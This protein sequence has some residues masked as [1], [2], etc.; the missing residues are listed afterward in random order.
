ME[1]I[2]KPAIPEHRGSVRE[3]IEFL[4]NKVQEQ[5]LKN[6]GVDKKEFK[7]GWKAKSAANKFG[8]KV[9]ENQ[10]LCDYLNKQG[11]WEG[12]VYLPIVGGN[13]IVYNNKGHEYRPREITFRKIGNK[14][15]PIYV[16]REID[17]K[18][19]SNRDWNAVKLRGDHTR[20]DELL[21]KMLLMAS[22]NKTEVKPQAKMILWIVGILA[23]VGVVAYVIFA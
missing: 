1:N 9:V 14:T 4:K 22:V 6:T 5:E 21:L 11:V 23:L 2:R 7:W 20:N 3:E 19:V 10:I 18:P 13:L 16:I 12:P 8:K 17:R 15:I